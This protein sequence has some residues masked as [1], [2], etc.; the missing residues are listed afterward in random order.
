MENVK[1]VQKQEK[2]EELLR[3]PYLKGISD[4]V[5]RMANQCGMELK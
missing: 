1:G 4:K 3:L 2:D 5:G